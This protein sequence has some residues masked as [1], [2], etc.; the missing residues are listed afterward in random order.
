MKGEIVLEGEKVTKYFGG[1]AALK[2]VDFYLRRGE[3]LGL[4]GPNGSGKTTL[5]NCVT[6]VVPPSS[7]VIRFKGEDITKCKPF[8]ICLKGISRSYQRVR[9]FNNLSVVENV[10]VGVFYGKGGKSVSMKEAKERARELAGYVGLEGKENVLCKNLTLA[11]QKKVELARALATEPEVLLLDE[12]AAGLNPTELKEV[13]DLIL[14]L[15]GE[16]EISIFMV[17]HVMKAIMGVS[18]RIIVLNFGN[19][20]AEG[21]PREIAT[22]KEVINVYLGEEYVW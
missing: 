13:M 15:R 16:R 20:I 2:D 17:E 9:V 6:N 14:K 21:S 5:F 18:D 8:N 19:K 1:L 4:I 10:M 12:I 11:D 3:I 22:N 7:G